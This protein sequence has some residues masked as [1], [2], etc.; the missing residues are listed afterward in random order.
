MGGNTGLMENDK[1]LVRPI[2]WSKLNK[3]HI[4]L[5]FID[6]REFFNRN[7]SSGRYSLVPRTNPMTPYE[8]SNWVKNR[9]DCL[10]YVAEDKVLKKIFASSVVIINSEGFGEINV[11][12][13]LFYPLRGAGT[14]LI[15]RTIE[16]TLSRNIYASIHTSV[17]NA[18]VIAIME[19][20]GYSSP[21][22]IKNYGPYVNNISARNF[23]AYEWIIKHS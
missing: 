23:D 5:D 6:I 10:N 19:K 3:I 11:L 7:L 17:E 4:P 9:R 22:W 12:R 2:D 18:P 1:F 14:E 8:L 15:K 16:E 13:D 20:L 21:K